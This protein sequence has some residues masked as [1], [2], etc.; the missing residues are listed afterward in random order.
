MSERFEDRLLLALESTV[1]SLPQEARRPDPSVDA[2]ARSA[3]LGA[4]R[5][6]RGWIIAAAAIVA[7]IAAF[8]VW[9]AGTTN[10]EVAPAGR[11]QVHDEAIPY[12]TFPASFAPK[13]DRTP[14]MTA[15][16][17]ARVRE[18]RHWF[19][20]VGGGRNRARLEV[21]EVDPEHPSQG[22]DAVTPAGRRVDVVARLNGSP[23]YPRVEF[24]L[25]G[26]RWIVMNVVEGDGQRLVKRHRL[27]EFIDSLTLDHERLSSS[28]PQFRPSEPPI[29][30]SRVV[31]STVARGF[32]LTAQATS[33]ADP[34]T[35]PGSSVRVRGVD[36]VLTRND[37]DEND[38][39]LG[40]TSLRWIDAGLTFSLEADWADRPLPVDQLVEVAES[41]VTVSKSEFEALPFDAA[42]GWGIDG[43]LVVRV[44]DPATWPGDNLLIDVAQRSS[45]GELVR[46]SRVGLGMSRFDQRWYP[47][48][49]AVRAA[50]DAVEVVVWLSGG[51]GGVEPPSCAR[52]IPIRSG[53]PTE[54]IDLDLTCTG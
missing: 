20:E 14:Q 39:E 37:M 6:R 34:S 22:E 9:P 10:V 13:Q 43:E 2:L 25:G 15:D 11:G 7:L 24:L 21:A 1:T 50:A 28:D 49:I 17:L 35:V 26:H 51:A 29:R 45:T 32:R 12:L 31:W 19:A 4:V 18:S 27:F 48:T 33:A 53:Q 38:G 47:Q 41:L 30:W 8:T 44:P 3:R 42:I 46:G 16:E 23:E 40:P 36:G 54:T 52:V 5:S